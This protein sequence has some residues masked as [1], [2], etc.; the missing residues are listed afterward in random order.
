[1][2]QA[3]KIIRD[4]DPVRRPI[5]ASLADTG[6]WNRF[7]NSP[8]LDFINIHPYPPS[9]QLDR[10]L[11][12]EIHKSLKEYHK[13]VLNGESGLNADSPEKYPPN[14]EIGVRHAMWAGLVSGAMNG[15]ALYWEDGYGLFFPS[16][17]WPFVRKYNLIELPASRFISGVDLSGVKPID[18]QHTP[19]ITGAAIGNDTIVIGWFRDAGAEPP[20]W[21]LQPVISKQTVTLTVAGT[22]PKWQVDFYNT[23]T[24]TDILGSASVERKGNN[25]TVNLPD[26]KDDIAFKLYVEGK[27][28]PAA[29]ITFPPI[30]AAPTQTDSIAQNWS[31]I[32]GNWTYSTPINISI[33]PGCKTGAVCGTFST[34]GAQCTGSLFLKEIQA[35]LFVFVEQ[36]VKGAALCAAGGQDFLVLQPDGS[37]LLRYLHKLSGGQVIVSGGTL[38]K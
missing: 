27:P 36:D 28:Q 34:P 15:R 33:Q 14:A 16:L 35:D 18:E 24:G 6:L 7:Y 2:E 23:Q 22:A 20:A 37:L 1:V 32:T 29:P 3:A 26:F 21:P 4:A 38:K 9:A 31:G 8:A 11:I 10:V 25:L 17:S 12:Q 13:P 30:P 19:K 5:T